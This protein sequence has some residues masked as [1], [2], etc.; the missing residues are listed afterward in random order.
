MSIPTFI[1]LSHRTINVQE[2]A[3]VSFTYPGN[4]VATIF[5]KQF[6][7]DGGTSECDSVKTDGPVEYENLRLYLETNNEPEWPIVHD[8]T[9]ENGNG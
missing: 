2:I 3:S 7:T 9:K 4:G 6:Y 8:F 5:L 1:K